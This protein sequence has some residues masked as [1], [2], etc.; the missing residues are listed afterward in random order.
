MFMAGLIS[1]QVSLCNGLSSAMKL[2]K[3]Q[4]R[5]MV[6]FVGMMYYFTVG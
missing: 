2:N 3:I 1:I 6:D 5:A 4:W